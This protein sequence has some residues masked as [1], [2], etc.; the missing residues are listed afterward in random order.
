MTKIDDTLY[1]CSVPEDIPNIIFNDGDSTQTED[2]ALPALSEGLN[3]Y[4]F[5][6]REWSTYGE[7]PSTEDPTE[8]VV[9]PTTPTEDSKDTSKS[10]GGLNIGLL[11]PII[12]AAVVVIA[13]VIVLMIK[14]KQK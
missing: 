9:D 11:I 6:S 7:E 1:S 10:D 13:L 14:K 3:L 8:P 12:A 5:I 4:D 2:L